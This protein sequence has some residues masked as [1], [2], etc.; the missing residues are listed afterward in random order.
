MFIDVNEFDCYFHTVI[1][2]YCIIESFFYLFIIKEARLL[3]N[4]LLPKRPL[5][6]K[7]YTEQIVD[8]ILNA[9]E[10]SNEDFRVCF[11]GWFT[12]VDHSSYDLIYEDNI[13]QFLTMATYG[14][15]SWDDLTEEKQKYVK[16]IFYDG[17]LK[18]YPEQRSNIKS[19]YNDK[20]QLRNPHRDAIPYVH[21]PLIKYLLFACIRYLSLMILN[22]MGFKC[23]SVG[24]IKFYVR[25][26]SKE[27]TR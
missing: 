8:R 22:F 21:Y 1:V 3:N 27:K 26:Y 24:K 17:Y 10:K 11:A 15:T 12:N 2:L 7:D 9:Y 23:Q 25:K 5:L 20:I 4:P 14:A 16:D 13:L 6:P 19:G 18:K